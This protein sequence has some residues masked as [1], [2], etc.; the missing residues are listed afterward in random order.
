MPSLVGSEMCIRDSLPDSIR[1][2][3]P[4]E[5][6]FAPHILNFL[7]LD[8]HGNGLDGEMLILGLDM[9]GLYVS[10]GSA[11]SSGT[12]KAS[13]VLTNLGMKEDV[14]RGAIRV[15]MSGRTTID[16][17]NRT[18]EIVSQTVLRM[19]SNRTA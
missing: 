10:A 18:A 15:S 2:N 5:G 13:S 11:C 19:T 1:F 3:S 6:E 9:A 8:D 12:M 17:I 16:E 4:T 14:A 7:C